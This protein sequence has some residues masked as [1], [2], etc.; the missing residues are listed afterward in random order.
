MLGSR[1][2][3]PGSIQGAAATAPLRSSSLGSCRPGPLVAAASVF[4]WGPG[5]ELPTEQLLNG[6]VT[7]APAVPPGLACLILSTALTRHACLVWLWAHRPIHLLLLA[8]RQT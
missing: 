8:A 1:Q 3:K 4:T 2:T 5:L 6:A 7:A